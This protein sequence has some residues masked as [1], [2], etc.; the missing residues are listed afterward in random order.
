M[1][2]IKSL[3]ELVQAIIGLATAIILYKTAKL[4]QK[5]GD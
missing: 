4:K 1:V 2:D 3:V 5:S